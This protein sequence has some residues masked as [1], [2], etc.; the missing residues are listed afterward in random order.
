MVEN[1]NKPVENENQPAENQVQENQLVENQTPSNQPPYQP[2]PEC[3][4]YGQPKNKKSIWRT[5]SI[6]LLIIAGL[7]I[8]IPFLFF[9][10]CFFLISTK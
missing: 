2:Y 3:D 6:V 10:G 8:A 1:E 5:V 4:Q 9:I 7:I